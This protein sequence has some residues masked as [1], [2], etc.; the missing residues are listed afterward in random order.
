[1]K[2]MAKKAMAL[3]LA[4]CLTCTAV[5]TMANQNLKVTKEEK[6]VKSS[7]NYVEGQA[8][9]M[10]GNTKTS[11]RSAGSNIADDDMEVVETY[12][13]NS[14][15]SVN[16]KSA[17]KV[18]DNG[19]S[20]SLVKSDKYSTKELISILKKK[21]NVKYAEPNY[22][23]KASDY[24]DSY[25]KYLWGLDN[26]GQNNGTEGIDVNADTPLL[27]NKDN[28]ERVIAI[29]DTGINY[30]HED[31]KEI[32]WNNPYNNRK[33]YGEHGYDFVNYDTDPM[34][35][36][37][38][39]S[40]CAG[41]AAGKSNNGVGIAGIAKSN[42]IKVMA[43]KILN[44]EGSG[45]GMGAI[46]AYNYIYK[47][48]QLGVNVVAVNNSWGGSADEE[49]E[50][51]KNLIELVGKKGAIS[52]C[53]A[54]NDNSDNDKNL[55]DNYPSTIDSPYIISVAASN[56]KDEL[57]G[58]SNYGTESVDI[59]A[60]GTDI[61]S[62]VSY[63][64]FNPGIYDNKDKLCSTY[65]NFDNESILNVFNEEG[66]MVAT[67][68][69]NE[70]AYGT[71]S[72]S[73]GNMNVSI[74]NSEYF[75][76]KSYNNKSLKWEIKGA[77]KDGMYFMCLPYTMKSSDTGTSA[78]VMV[79]VSGPKA[80][81]DDWLVGN[82]SVIYAIDCKLDKNGK[83]DI[84]DLDTLEDGVFASA[85]IDE[86]GNYWSHLSGEVSSKSKKDEQHVI[87]L[88]VSSYEEGDFAVYVDNW[89]ISRENV[90]PDEFGMYDYYNGTSMATP[91]VTG[92]VA[93][94]ANA[95]TNENALQIKARILG[96][97]RNNDNFKGKIS[98]GGALDLSKIGKPGMTIDKVLLNGKK[99][100]EISGYYTDNA[101]VYI[102]DKKINVISNNGKTIVVD[103]KSYQNKSLKVKLIKGDRTYEKEYFFA[104]GS[105]FTKGPSVEAD[106]NGG[107]MISNG[108]NLIYIDSTGSVS[109]GMTYKDDETGK[110]EF[111]WR[112]GGFTFTPD[113]FGK[114][115]ENVAD[116]NVYSETDY[117]CSN[118]V[119]YGCI[120]LDQGFAQ[121]TIL[122]YYDD[123]KGWKKLAN[124]PKEKEELSG[125]ILAAYNGELYLMG[126]VDENDNF[127]K[128]VMKYSTTS[129]K[130]SVT[131][132]LSEGRAYS[133][134]MQVGK[135]LIVTLGS[136]GTMNAP[137]NLIY[138]GTKW[139][140]SKANIGKSIDTKII[141]GRNKK[142]AVIMGEIGLVKGGII[143]T[144]LRVDSLGDTFTYDIAK[145]KFIA[146]KYALNASNLEFD[147]LY[148]TTAGDKLYVVYG[149]AMADDDGK[150]F[151]SNKSKLSNKDFYDED[152][153]EDDAKILCIPIDSGAVYVEDTSEFGVYVEGTGYYLPGD[154]VT[155]KAAVMDKKLN[156][157][158][159]IVNGKSVKKGK[160]GYVYTARAYDLPAKITASVKAEDT[161]IYIKPG[162]TSIT[163][164]VRAKNNRSIKLTLK[165]AGTA[166][167]YQIKYSTSKKFGKKVTKTVN[168]KKNMA[169]IKKLSAKKTYYIKARA[170][171]KTGKSKKYGSWSKVKTVKVKKK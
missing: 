90:S 83:V 24:N 142:F 122:S 144:N 19:F 33:L 107:Q 106:L 116:A 121:N 79:K 151:G 91:Y 103:G 82:D 3:T 62:T 34:D 50:I 149:F 18:S 63:N 75:G 85:Y 168:T 81:N 154:T 59:A 35:D 155:L 20:V 41:I 52:V 67:P 36:N 76:E 14:D 140:K 39:G 4:M 47:A 11:T 130:W 23:I 54:G 109:A 37:G 7:R 28:K 44:E 152:D 72:E 120:T 51:I 148:A 89:G 132:S 112:G 12:V 100:I 6:A 146:S 169:V 105:A 86:N 46:G 40:H 21:S 45:S 25:Y 48:Q 22:K 131:K 158:Q 150:E 159:F 1:M 171:R 17:D 78:S 113:V 16:A 58:F 60:P 135:K 73:A 166:T 145:D 118:G 9:V 15:T 92:A 29:V 125:V 96:S 101:E 114:E 84:S 115:Y 43:L 164:A 137:Y 143:Y 13:F 68:E 31:L 57:A 133:R 32:V 129:K 95:Y 49:D 94:V 88:C 65:V 70:V 97:T 71:L 5:P 99:Q 167:G 74:T 126:G 80:T 104:T 165:K 128:T 157:S 56:E 87:L 141:E 77:Q 136:D 119:V 160:T 93:A 10:Y 139:T 153:Y 138:D 110:D 127:S 66:K 55:M 26:K 98:T 102:N 61:L 2:R 30:Q 8:I 42:N 117:V 108:G 27:D 69:N 162:K 147:N 156:I 163:K 134:A 170:Y 161:D 64:C 38:H 124:M 111:F 123:E 53:A